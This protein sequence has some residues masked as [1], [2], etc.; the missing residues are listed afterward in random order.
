M[1]SAG[2]NLEDSSAII[3]IPPLLPTIINEVYRRG[4]NTI[5][6]R[7]RQR[8]IDLSEIIGKSNSF[9]KYLTG[10]CLAVKGRKK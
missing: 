5:L 4:N 1:R 6:A 7:I 2:F 9:L 10:Y 8:I 3:H